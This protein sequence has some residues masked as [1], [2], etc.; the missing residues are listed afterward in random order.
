MYT[1]GTRN[2]IFTACRDLLRVLLRNVDLRH[3]PD[4]NDDLLEELLYTCLNCPGFS[5]RQRWEFTRCCGVIGLAVRISPL[6]KDWPFNVLGRKPDVPEDVME[7]YVDRLT[8]HLANPRARPTMNPFRTFLL[9]PNRGDAATF[10][11]MGRVELDC[12]VEVYRQ[13]LDG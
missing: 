10:G 1:V 12:V 4:L 3:N 9:P 2:H 6:A 7:F 5:E 11:E 8:R 13:T